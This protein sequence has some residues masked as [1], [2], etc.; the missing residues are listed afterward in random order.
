VSLGLIVQTPKEG[1]WLEGGGDVEEEESPE[2]MSSNDEV[3]DVDED[4]LL[5][6]YWRDY[7]GWEHELYLRHYMSELLSPRGTFDEVT[8]QY[9]LKVMGV[10]MERFHFIELE[11]FCSFI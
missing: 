1:G 10:N 4:G 9:V 11:R 7:K 2:D 3:E 5:M 6:G 8:M